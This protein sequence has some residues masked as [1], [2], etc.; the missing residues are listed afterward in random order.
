[1]CSLP[2]LLYLAYTA[3][4]GRASWRY[5]VL[6]QVASSR[7]AVH[8]HAFTDGQWVVA[9]FTRNT[10]NVWSNPELTCLVLRKAVCCRFAQRSAHRSSR[11]SRASK[12]WPAF[13]YDFRAC[14]VRRREDRMTFDARIFSLREGDLR[15]C[16]R[17]RSV[18]DAHRL[19]VTGRRRGTALEACDPRNHSR[20]CETPAVP[21]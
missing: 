1:M 10:G 7:C 12:V 18:G 8:R 14:L 17:G 3:A 4:A 13:G 11:M 5:H 9:S 21:W 19:T 15:Q 20:H 2:R 6:Q 16:S